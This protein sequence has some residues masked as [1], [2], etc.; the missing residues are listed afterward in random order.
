MIKFIN[1]QNKLKDFKE[2]ANT[3]KQ[4]TK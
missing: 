1:K 2:E 3:R 4:G